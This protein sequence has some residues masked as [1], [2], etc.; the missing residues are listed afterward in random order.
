MLYWLTGT[1]HSAGRLY[2]EAQ[3]SG[4]G[5]ASGER[6]EVPTGVAAFPRE[7]VSTPRTWVEAYYNI[8]HWSEMPRG[9]HFAAM[10]EGELLVGDI[11]ECFRPLRV[12]GR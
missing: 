11:R 9:G 2:Y 7:I 12:V 6:V 4:R 10:E 5:F 1:A 8:V 3:R